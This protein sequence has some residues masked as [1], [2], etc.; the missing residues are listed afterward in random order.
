MNSL[1]PTKRNLPDWIDAY[2]E[3]IKLNRTT[4]R[5]RRWAAVSGVGGALTRRC[6]VETDSGK[7]YPNTY[8]LLIG[9]PGTGKDLAINPVKHIWASLPPKKL[10]LGPSS[11][12]AKGIIDELANEKSEFEYIDPETKT[13]VPFCS[14][15]SSVAELGTMIPEYN[16]SQIS[17]M[18]DLWGANPE[19][20]ERTRSGTGTAIVLT[21][22]VLH[23]LLATQPDFF[24]TT[25][26]VEAFGMGFFART[27]MIFDEEL[28]PVDPV[29]NKRAERKN[30]VKPNRARDELQRKLI[31]DLTSITNMQGEFH[32]EDKTMDLMT[33][34]SLNRA[35]HD[36][37]T[38]GKF[39]SY[40]GRRFLHIMKLTMAFSA[41]RSSDMIITPLDW[42]NSIEMLHEAEA[43]MPN[44]FSEMT[45][46]RGSS[47]EF[48]EILQ[49]VSQYAEEKKRS[50]PEH[51][52][53]RLLASRV[54]PH[55]ITAIIESAVNSR[56]ISVV[57]K[58]S[59]DERLFTIPKGKK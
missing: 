54:P 13:I 12:S 22:P 56:I 50:I 42:R 19:M 47:D 15:I 16:P 33:D 57:G 11:M 30:K 24:G 23:M 21:R 5:F 53:I 52:L 43:V 29:A 58:Q 51:K 48:E 4:P 41:S 36:A 45:F 35:K 20:S 38:H 34:W 1:A 27:V 37:L 3:S 59:N 55:Q 9:K 40:N 8:I 18:T 31:L 17:I 26:P 25:F 10:N 14:V 6:W 2:V 32:L 49:L 44:I 7:I 28:P 46:S 39:S